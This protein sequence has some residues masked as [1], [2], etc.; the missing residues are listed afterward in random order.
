MK[1]LHYQLILFFAFWAFGVSPQPV[2]ASGAAAKRSRPPKQ[3]M[4]Q[5]QAMIQ[6]QMIQQQMIQKEIA[7]RQA[8][9]IGVAVQKTVAQTIANN[10]PPLIVQSEVK[11][12]VDVEY[13]WEALETSSEVWPLMID[14]QAKDMVVSR[15]IDLYRSK[16]IKI[17]K[18]AGYYSQLIDGMSSQN[19]E[20]LKN[21][22]AQLL[23]TVAIIEYDFD[24]GQNKDS[25]AI[26]ILGQKG[27][28][29][30]KK[31]LGIH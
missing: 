3:V 14:Q 15:Y 17:K 16:G 29:A 31:R 20:M 27:Y 7:Q 2:F 11:Q 4:Q 5:K 24:N 13:I 18:P 9:Q 21:P 1:T 10:P 25:L 23:Q 28:E 12:I 30:N 26:K 6:K 8:Q 19:P 22:F